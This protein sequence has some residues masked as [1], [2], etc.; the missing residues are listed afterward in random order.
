MTDPR[1]E[2]RMAYL[3]EFSEALDGY[4]DA[5]M[6]IM[7]ADH[8]RVSQ[9]EWAHADARRE[10]LRLYELRVDQELAHRYQRS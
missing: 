9:A 5:V 3:R 1:D 10:V 8:H 7:T 4:R 6:A 2:L